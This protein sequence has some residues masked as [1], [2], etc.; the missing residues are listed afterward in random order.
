MRLSKVVLLTVFLFGVFSVFKAPGDPDFGWH[1]KYGEYIAQHGKILRQNTFSYTFTDYKW[2]NSYWISQVA[3]YLTH[4][5]LG[6]LIAGLLFAGVLSASAIFYVRTLSKKISL[7]VFLTAVSTLLLFT[8]FSGSGITGRPMYFSTLFLMLLVALLFGDFEKIGTKPRRFVKF[9]ILPIMFLIWANAHADFVLGLFVLGLY[10][11]NKIIDMIRTR[12]S[13]DA[14]LPI[15]GLLS[16]AVTLINPYGLSLWQ[17]LIKES[18][19]YQFTY[20]SEWVPASTDNIYYF[21]VY[22]VVLGLLVSALIGARYKLPAWYLL[23]LGFFCIASVRSQYFFRIAVILG[24][25]AFISFWSDPLDDLKRAFSPSLTKKLK[26]SFLAFLALSTLVISTLFL[27]D[28]SQCVDPNYWVEK[29]EYPRDA[30]DFALASNIK[31]NVFN[32]YGWGG[33]M[34]W[35]YPQYKT[36]VDGRMPSWREG[37][38]SVFE[39][40]MKVVSAP[41]KNIKILGDYEVTWIL[42][43]SESGLVKFLRTP[44]SGWREVYSNE[45]SS[46]FVETTKFDIITP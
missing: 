2:A 40:Y 1:Y 7:G 28:V 41:K 23:A 44:N 36:F 10:I 17:T 8:E 43:P 30:L 11:G 27:T 9:L 34:I 42:Y 16:V 14:L 4:H 29:E 39:D 15:V 24:I 31:G 21:I 12:S 3:M 19:P 32:Y 22:C 6:H 25:P 26:I 38:K 37:N 20:I 13:K 45:F 5:Y 33:Y 18:H 46:V 35:K